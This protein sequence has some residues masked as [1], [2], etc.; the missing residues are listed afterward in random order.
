M[1]NKD[2]V[3]AVMES[4]RKH[5]VPGSPSSPSSS[6]ASRDLKF[7]SVARLWAGMG[8]IYR[9]DIDTKSSIDDNTKQHSRIV[10]HVR[11]PSSITSRG[12]QCKA[13]SYV[14]EANFYEHL[15]PILR[16]QHHVN[17]PE[18]FMWNDRKS[19]FSLS[20]PLFLP[21]VRPI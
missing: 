19:P 2:L 12:D 3:N 17:L 4:L 21:G 8:Y 13:D 7:H 9:V 6:Y 20:C 15:V 5:P 10:K 18:P 16:A 11:L 14:V 1:V